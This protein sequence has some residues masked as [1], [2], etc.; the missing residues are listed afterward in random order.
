MNNNGKISRFWMSLVGILFCV[1][2]CKADDDFT[3]ETDKITPVEFE[4]GKIVSDGIEMPYRVAHINGTGK[5]SLVIYLHGGSSKGNNNEI[6]MSEA[7]VD[8]IANYL[9]SRQ[10]EA[11]YL[12]PQCP[13]DK[14]W[15][16][17]M[18][19]V[20]KSLIDKY[21]GDGIVNENSLYILGG[22]MGGTGTWSMLSA[23][24]GLFTAAMP[25]AGNPSKCDADK[26]ASTPVCTVMGTS[27]RIMSVETTSD[28]INELN[29]RNGITKFEV[30]DGWTHEMTC[31]QSYTTHR[32]DWVFSHGSNPSGIENPMA[33]NNFIKSVQYYSID[34][35]ILSEPP[36]KGLYIIRCVN[37]DGSGGVHRL[38][39]VK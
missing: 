30:E 1:S 2:G 3:F 35:R 26:V 11:I 21:V 34:G 36:S 6:Q 33:G 19:G 25:V 10:I 27:D 18:L 16:G 28:F 22:S 12:V 38:M 29:A 23:Y 13:S 15:G 8:S 4:T 5:P 20:L 37:K 31:I 17:P 24:P 9:E 32:L 7:G 39:M 14:S